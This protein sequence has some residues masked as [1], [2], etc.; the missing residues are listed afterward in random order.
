[1]FLQLLA[2]IGFFTFLPKYLEF[3]FRKSASS[4]GLYGGFAKAAM[5]C[6]GIFISGLIVSKW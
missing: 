6:L 2:M 4:S 1:M 5:G 3:V